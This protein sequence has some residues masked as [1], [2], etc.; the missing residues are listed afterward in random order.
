MA[1]RP[2]Q[3]AP[4][5]TEA[6][7]IEEYRDPIELFMPSDEVQKIL[8]STPARFTGEFRHPNLLLT[9]AWPPF[10]RGRH[11]WLHHQ[12]SPIG[13]T[14]V[15][16]VF[17]TPP[18]RKAP[19]V[20]VPNYERA[21]DHV[22]AALSVLFGKRFDVH[23]PLEMSGRFGVPDMTRFAAPVNPALPYN[24]GR[25]RVDYPVP[26]QLSEVRRMSGLLL[27]QDVDENA[28]ATFH[29]AAAFY[30]R[31]LQSAEDDPEVAYL[32]LITA[33]EILSASIPFDEAR[34]LD[35]DVRGVLATVAGLP[36]G[37]RMARI[38]LARLRGIKKRFVDAITGLVDE[39]FF[40]RTE[41]MEGVG[42]L[43]REDFARRIAAAYDL[44]SQ[45]VHT[46][47]E[48]GGWIAADRLGF[49][50]QLG[51]PVVQNR[52]MAKV[53]KWAPLF[54]GLERVIRYALLN[55]G[56]GVGLDLDE[57]PEL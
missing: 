53:L 2:Q 9:H 34:H 50:V 55:H 32:H 19:G 23:G 24:G 27:D 42:G 41:A 1:D 44:R 54:A 21:G 37:G 45:H 49:E 31:A 22:A 39:S 12:D 25:P 17:R 40:D 13:R 18:V 5:E 30:R 57:L 36:G 3:P 28:S 6:Q 29:G 15:V 33:G 10:H 51:D 16:V 46:G 48:F 43:R 38:L 56:T 52:E 11:D 26:L 14:A 35:D 47:Y 8:L 7:A 4:A 20:V